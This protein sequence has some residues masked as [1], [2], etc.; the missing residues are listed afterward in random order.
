MRIVNQSNFVNDY[1]KNE[2]FVLGVMSEESAKR[3]S[4]AINKELSGYDAPRFF[5]VVPD[6]Y[7]LNN[8]EVEYEND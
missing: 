3:I 6:D 2:T 5:G 8:E 7:V 4:R 1:T